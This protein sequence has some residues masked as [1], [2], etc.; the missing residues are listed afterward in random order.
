MLVMVFAI[1]LALLALLLIDPLRQR[2][3][4]RRDLR[5]TGYYEN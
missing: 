4:R 1:S 5:W 3:H 2:L